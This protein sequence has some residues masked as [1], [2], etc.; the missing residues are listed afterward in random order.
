[1]NF[2][3]AMECLNATIFIEAN[4]TRLLLKYSSTLLSTLE[5]FSTISDNLISSKNNAM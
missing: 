4:V 1:M 5:I 2:L 3:H